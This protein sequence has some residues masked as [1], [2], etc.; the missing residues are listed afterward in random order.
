MPDVAA[1]EQGTMTRPYAVPVRSSDV[2]RGGAM[3]TRRSLGEDL[4]TSS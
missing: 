3:A 4:A 1:T 2:E